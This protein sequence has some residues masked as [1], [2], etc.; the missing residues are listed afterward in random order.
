MNR[1]HSGA[2][3][4]LGYVYAQQGRYQEAIAELQKN[5]ELGGIDTRGSLGQVYAIAGQRGAAQ[6]LLTQLQVEGKHKHVSPYNIAKIYAGLGEQEQAFVWL[7]KALAERDSNL[8][9][10]GLNVDVV[11]ESLHADPRFAALLRR[12]GLTS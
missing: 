8:T 10:P 12:M 2:H 5:T 4:I 9:D 7:E 3:G 11:F 1:N 6:K